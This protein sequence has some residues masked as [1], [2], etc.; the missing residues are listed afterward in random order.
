MTTTSTNH[1]GPW[2]NA[3]QAAAYL[4]MP[5]VKA[6]YQAV[7]RGQIPVHRFGSRLRFHTEELDKVLSQKHRLTLD[8]ELISYR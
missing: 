3:K 6:V 4:A 1:P 7:R 2:L 8:Q 5:S